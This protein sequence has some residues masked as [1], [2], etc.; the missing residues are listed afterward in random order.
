[1]Q[2]YAEATSTAG[3]LSVSAVDVVMYLFV[4]IFVIIVA[5]LSYTQIRTSRRLE[6]LSDETIRAER[7]R[8]D[9]RLG[10][11]ARALV[12]SE[13]R[14]LTEL[15]RTARF[16]HLSQGLFHDLMNP[17]AAL[18][19][20]AEEMSTR[21]TIDARG[22]NMIATMLMTSKR[23]GSYM[24]S[25]RRC[26][27]ADKTHPDETSDFWHEADIVRDVVAYQARRA[28]VSIIIDRVDQTPLTIAIHPVRLHQLLLNL[29]MNGIDACIEKLVKQPG[30]DGMNVT[31]NARRRKDALVISVK[32]TGIGIATEIRARLFQESFT[33]KPKGTGIGLMTVKD[34]VSHDLK[35]TI[36]VKSEVGRGTEFVITVP[37][38][39]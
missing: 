19:L 28:N 15:D 12:H 7:L 25:V 11:R 18:T 24:D 4:A 32:D 34:I 23:I 16:G 39:K 5:F 26:L 9:Q 2:A 30:L 36:E 1:M 10:E 38:K 6:E 31:M 29:V 35:G 37:T 14:R 8:F 13:E 21:S 33:T 22:R 17:L 27:E 3:T 20:Y